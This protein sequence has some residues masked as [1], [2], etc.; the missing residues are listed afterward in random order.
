MGKG[1]AGPG[2]VGGEGG[3]LPPGFDRAEQGQDRHQHRDDERAWLRPGVP[4]P[5]PQPIMQTDHRV[6]PGDHQG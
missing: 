6:A 5:D 3:D 2:G 4:R 1:G